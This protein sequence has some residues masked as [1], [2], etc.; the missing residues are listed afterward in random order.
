M[1]PERWQQVKDLFNAALERDATERRSFLDRACAGDPGLR[2]EVEDLLISDE[3]TTYMIDQPV[4][5]FAAELLAQHQPPPVPGRTVGPYK[6]IKQIGRGGMGEVYLARDTRLDRPVAIKMLPDSFIHD[7]ERVRRFQQEARAASLLNHPNIVTIHEMAESEQQRFIVSEYVEGKTLREVMNA[8]GFRLEQALDIVIQTAS[9]LGAAHNAGIIHRDIKPENIMVRPDGYVKVLDFGLAKLTERNNQ[10]AQGEQSAGGGEAAELSTRTGIVMGTVKYMSPEQARGEK[11]DRRTDIFSLGVVLYEAIT[12]HAPFD[13]KTPSHTI[14]AI[15][16][17]EPL[18]LAKYLSEVPQA[19]EA[20]VTKILSKDRDARYQTAQE[21]LADLKRLKQQLEFEA[22][23][24]HGA[25]DATP[26]K[27]TSVRSGEAA[28]R[29]TSFVSLNKQ[30]AKAAGIILIALVV[31]AAAIL[32]FSRRAPALTERDTILLADFVNTTGDA[33]FDG[34]LKQALAVQLEQSPF[35]NIYSAEQVRDAL[36]YMAR[37]PDDRVTKDIAREIC[38]RQGIKAMLS[39]TISNLG[40]NHVIT[41]EAVNAQTGEVIA[42]Q[43]EEAESKEQVLASLGK[44]ATALREKLGESLASIQR[45]DAPIEQATTSSLEALKAFS[46]AREQNFGGEDFAAISHLKRAV[47]LDPNFAAAYSS[48]AAGYSNTRQRELAALASQRAFE[49]RDRASERERL[50]I[51][52]SYYTNVTGEVDK[53]IEV[54]EQLKQTYPRLAAPRSNLSLQ[55]YNTGQYEKAIEEARESIRI[56]PNSASYVNLGTSFFR[57][58]RF[59]EAKE[60]LEQ[61]TTQKMDSS[62][63]HWGLYLVGFIQGDAEAMQQQIDWCS[64]RPDE[65][66]HMYWQAGTA[67]F[68]G[69]LRKAKDLYDRAIAVMLRR[70][71]K[72]NAASSMMDRAVPEA[73]VGLCQQAKQGVADGLVIDRTR[74]ASFNAAFVSAFCGDLKQAQLFADEFARRFP[75]STLTNNIW[76]PV[77]RATMEIRRGNPAQAIQL[78]QSAIPYGGAGNRWPNYIRGLAYLDQHD[79]AAAAAEF[80]TLLDHRGWGPTFYLYPL[81]HL[82]LARAAALTGD[83]VKS[84]IAYQDFFALWKDADSDI[85]ILVEAK[86][87]YEKLK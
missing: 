80:Q 59:D 3:Q 37:S 61:A 10:R 31:T 11:V 45:F 86:K 51:T 52:S 24:R 48:L 77:I 69:Q 81:A 18:P 4:L 63:S 64:R 38:Q 68:H 20:I 1:T 70:D 26:V 23:M 2:K 9:A 87:E 50:T 43:Q 13:G 12:G 49:L 17:R 71:L 7:A 5:E 58:D 78:L 19:L 82:G 85:P 32:F 67:P 60:I 30:R 34:T 40:G 39:G 25:T 42:R 57:L 53:N 84:R 8:D 15:L 28:T 55:Y 79:G 35:L 22:E 54:L 21:L 47:E 66:E 83:T 27:E 75:K 72:E 16:E 14:V 33:V 29:A 46:L 76:L 56:K 74:G 73:I 41:L 36:R 6:F 44:A 65:Y 62:T